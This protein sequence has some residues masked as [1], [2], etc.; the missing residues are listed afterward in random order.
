MHSN[1]VWDYSGEVPRHWAKKDFY[2]LIG[3]PRLSTKKEIEKGFRKLLKQVHPDRH[4]KCKAAAEDCL[5]VKCA[6]HNMEKLTKYVEFAKTVLQFSRRP[7][8]I[9]LQDK[10]PADLP[11]EDIFCLVPGT[12]VTPFLRVA[13]CQYV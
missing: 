12:Q 8:D 13:M 2:K 5:C 1:S 10:A 9:F 7:Y 3:V 4:P 6:K 11:M